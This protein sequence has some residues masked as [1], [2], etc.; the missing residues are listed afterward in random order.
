MNRGHS[1]LALL[2][3]LALATTAA[4]LATE[5][6]LT[7]RATQ[8]QWLRQ[9]AVERDARDALFLLTRDLRQ[10]GVAGCHVDPSGETP[11]QLHYGAPGWSVQAVRQDGQ[12]RITALQLYE[13]DRSQPLPARVVVSSCR[14]RD[15]FV[16]G[17][18]ARLERSASSLMLT[19]AVAGALPVGGSDGHHL[20]SLGAAPWVALR[21]QHAEG[22]LW[23]EDLATGLRQALA[24]A[25][26][27]AADDLGHGWTLVLQPGK[28]KTSPPVWTFTA[29]RQHGAVLPIVL[30]L[31]AAA[32]LALSTA[33]RVL[34]DESR[35]VGHQA[36]WGQVLLAAEL[37]L[38]EAEND[39]VGLD[40]QP[41]REHW[42][43]V[44][45]RNPAAAAAWRQGLCS[46]PADSHALPVWAADDVLAPCGVA[47]CIRGGNARQR[48]LP[49]CPAE[50]GRPLPA[51]SACYVV[52]LLDGRFRGEAG[53]YRI[54]ARA[55]DRRMRSVVT[56]QS[57]FVAGDVPERLSW[58][59]LW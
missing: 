34:L 48:P 21:Y 30:A 2:V 5:R 4:M 20:P 57:H 24:E 42:F 19:P 28:G 31:A 32:M 56:L 14:R 17:V 6:F 55:W 53:L 11:L 41:G 44:P 27:F 26:T 13:A 39:V 35:L 38:G 37:A 25:E 45:C 54:T 47:A 12:G 33:Q 36:S 22:V 18:D 23:R 16:V 3:A 50:P 9:A 7:L 40:R 43:T 59:A 1:L 52:E 10:H 49:A 46:A 8:S 15:I 29:K 58:S 51:D